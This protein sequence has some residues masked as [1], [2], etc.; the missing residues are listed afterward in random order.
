MWVP[1]DALPPDST[2]RA[3]RPKVLIVDAQREIPKAAR[4]LF[5][6]L[7]YD[8][9]LSQASPA[10]AGLVRTAMHEQPRLILHALRAAAPGLES[11]LY[12]LKENPATARIPIVFFAAE[13]WTGR[14]E[15][16]EGYICDPYGPEDLLGILERRQAQH[17][18]AATVLGRLPGEGQ[19]APVAPVLE[20][21]ERG[22]RV[23]RHY[24]L[25]LR[26]AGPIGHDIEGPVREM[27]EEVG[28]LR[29]VAGELRRR[30]AYSVVHDV[31]ADY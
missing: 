22:L 23:L 25:G 19:D 31:G 9:V 28:M 5:D 20:Q 18:P 1:K 4:D 27:E 24:L 15:E 12:A 16:L 13:P 26:Q 10:G 29:D 30:V 2:T 6:A 14:L 8:V 7:G 11:T 3:A 17:R 21:L